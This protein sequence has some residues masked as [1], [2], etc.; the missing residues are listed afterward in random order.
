MRLLLSELDKRLC[1]KLNKS[2]KPGQTNGIMDFGENNDY[3][4]ITESIINSSITAKVVSKIFAKFIIGQGFENE[5]LNT[6]IVGKDVRGKGFTLLDM[7]RSCAIDLSKHNGCYIHSY[8]T[9]G[10]FIPE[11]R[12]IPF[13]NCRFTKQDDLGYCS[14]IAVY[15]NWEKNSEKKFEKEK[16]KDYNVFNFN[17]EVIKSQIEKAGEDAYKGQVNFLFLDNE[18]LYPLSNIDSIYMDCDSENQISIYKNNQ[19]RNGFLDKVVMRVQPPSNENERDEFIE[20]VKTFAGAD[21]DPVLILE[22]E[23]DENGEIKK[24]GAFAIDKI[25]SNIN[26]K[27]FESWEK[28]LTNNIRKSYYALPALLIDYEESKLGTTSGEAITQAVNFYNSMTEDIRKGLSSFFKEIYKNF[29]NEILKAN[30]N[31]NIKPLKLYDN[32]TVTKL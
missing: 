1:V 21:G 9:P 4:Q 22:D 24:T 27:L 23:I 16:I 14:K 30:D 32:G 6:I 19:L 5:F 11:T 12:F 13:K 20:T 2:I 15:D 31:W 17:E 18:Y 25:E 7:L 29:D 3:P 10:L 8:I 28:S 26:D